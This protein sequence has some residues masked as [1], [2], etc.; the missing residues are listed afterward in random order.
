MQLSVQPKDGKF[1][2]G[3]GDGGVRQPQSVQSV[4]KSQKDVSLPGPPS[5]Q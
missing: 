1:D 3:G 5:S 4:F 2:G